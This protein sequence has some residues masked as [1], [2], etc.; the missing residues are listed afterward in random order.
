[1]NTVEAYKTEYTSASKKHRFLFESNGTRQIIKAIEYTYIQKMDG[2]PVF[3]L[4]FGDYDIK[5]GEILDS[6][7]SN[8]GDMYKVFNTVLTT[9]PKFFKLNKEA[10]IF[11]QGSD[12][13]DNFMKICKE[14]CKKDC[15][16]IC[17]NMNRR[18]NTYRYF[19]NKNFDQLSKE[20]IFFGLTGGDNPDFVQYVPHNEYSGILVYKKK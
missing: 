7:N 5:S 11:V 17:R 1:M 18:I 3:N 4:G 6:I 2:V 19:V 20:Y 14:T 10:A 16:N 8:N 15:E 9:V 13:T 12:G